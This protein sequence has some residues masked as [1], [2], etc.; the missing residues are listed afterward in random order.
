MAVEIAEE[1]VA[2]RL[3]YKDG[4]KDLQQQVVAG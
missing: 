1:E 4:L 2:K 3:G